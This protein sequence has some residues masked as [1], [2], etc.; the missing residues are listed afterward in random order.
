MQSFEVF[1]ALLCCDQLSSECLGGVGVL[2]RLL[3]VTGSLR[4]ISQVDGLPGI[5]VQLLDLVELTAQ[6][7]LELALVADDRRGLL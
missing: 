3:G 6:L 7:H 4:L 1:D 5:G 2:D